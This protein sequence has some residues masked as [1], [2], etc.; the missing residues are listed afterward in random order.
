MGYGKKIHLRTTAS[1]AGCVV[2]K[3]SHI[4]AYGATWGKK[5][6]PASRNSFNKLG[7]T[8]VE[9]SAGYRNCFI[10]HENG[11]YQDNFRED[12]KIF[13]GCDVIIDS[14]QCYYSEYKK[15]EEMG[16]GEYGYWR[17][18]KGVQPSEENQ[19]ADTSP[20]YDEEGGYW[21]QKLRGDHPIVV[22]GWNSDYDGVMSVPSEKSCAV[23]DIAQWTLIDGVWYSNGELKQEGKD[24]ECVHYHGD[25][26]WK[27]NAGAAPP[28]FIPGLANSEENIPY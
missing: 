24:A 8:G 23:L 1:M 25:G 3:L 16:P 22:A 7:Q 12:I 10:K 4:S 5:L 11:G 26:I 20:A 18:P 17:L 6:S 28:T 2:A 21:R 27:I 14:D 9:T 19:N 13:D 15:G